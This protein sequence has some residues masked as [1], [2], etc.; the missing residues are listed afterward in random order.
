MGWNFRRRIQLL[1]G[2]RLNVGKTS[3]SV[4]FGARGLRTTV[5]KRGITTT[6]GIPGSGLSYT[7]NSA[8]TS[9]PID[10][11]ALSRKLLEER[12]HLE[13][14]P[15]RIAFYQRR[16]DEHRNS[17]SHLQDPGPLDCR[18]CRYERKP[19]DPGPLNICPNCKCD[20]SGRRAKRSVVSQIAYQLGMRWRQVLYGGAF[21]LTVAIVYWIKR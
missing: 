8:A 9:A 15:A 21:V 7:T 14:S 10:V 20:L 17:Q 6:V 5:G 16:R 13:E 11:E 2:I 1:P 19:A 4:S 12:Q 3:A 18:A